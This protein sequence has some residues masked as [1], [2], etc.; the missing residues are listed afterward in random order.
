MSGSNEGTAG[1]VKEDKS[2]FADLEGTIIEADE[3]SV[4][5]EPQSTGKESPEQAAEVR[6][7]QKD[8]KHYSCQTMKLILMKTTVEIK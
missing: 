1:G 7:P 4:A 6:D 3:E 8:D 2:P 5:D